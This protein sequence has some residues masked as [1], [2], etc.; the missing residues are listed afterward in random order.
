MRSVASIH[1]ALKGDVR[2]VLTVHGALASR[3]TLGGTAPSSLKQQLKDAS[4]TTAAHKKEFD[5]KSKAFSEMMG[6]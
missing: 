5:D 1:P 3:T 4:A 2:D 6:A